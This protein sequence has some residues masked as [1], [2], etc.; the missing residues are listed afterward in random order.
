MEQCEQ[1]WRLILKR[2]ISVIKF[3]AERGLAFRGDNQL[4]R[5]PQNG[6]YLGIL[7]LISQCDDFL[8]QHIQIHANKGSG[9]T[10]YLSS[11]IM[12]EIVTNVGELVLGKILC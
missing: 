10:N 5:S 2:V 3:I 12:K 1:Y 8:A 11:T 9:H 7:E 6:N 4:M